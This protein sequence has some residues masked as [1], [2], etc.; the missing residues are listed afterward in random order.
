[1]LVELSECGGAAACDPVQRGLA[2]MASDPESG[3]GQLYRAFSHIKTIP[4]NI[5]LSRQSTHGP[6]GRPERSITAG[7]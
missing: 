7:R 1:M 5:G 2:D 3:G 6:G 4:D